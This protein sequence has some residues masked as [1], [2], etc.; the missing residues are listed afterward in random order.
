MRDQAG[1]QLALEKGLLER[2]KTEPVRDFQRVPDRTVV[3]DAAGR[4]CLLPCADGRGR[5]F[6][7]ALV[8]H[9]GPSLE[10]ALPA[11]TNAGY[12]AL[13]PAA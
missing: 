1:F 2:Q 4:N 9:C 13:S 3:A 12:R 11:H 10:P 5:R 7:S 8:A 6:R